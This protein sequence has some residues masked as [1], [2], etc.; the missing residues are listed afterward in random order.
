MV[1]LP[2]H[3]VIGKQ[4]YVPTYVFIICMLYIKRIREKKKEDTCIDHTYQCIGMIVKEIRVV[5]RKM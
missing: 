5:Y 4:K 2:F 1:Y 3:K